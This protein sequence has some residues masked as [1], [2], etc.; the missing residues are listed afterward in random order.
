MRQVPTQNV[1]LAWPRAIGVLIGLVGLVVLGMAG[2]FVAMVEIWW[3]SETFAHGFLIAPIALYLVYRKRDALQRLAP[4]PT[5]WAVPLLFG[6]GAVWSLARLVDVAVIEQAAAVAML[7]LVVWAVLGTAVVRVLLFPLAY[8]FFM[9]PVGEGLIPPLMDFTAR[10]TVGAIRLVG[11]PVF[12][13]GTFFSIPSGNWSVVEGCSG[14]RYLIASVALGALYTYLS[15]KSWVRRLCFMG[16]F[17]VVPIIANGMRAFMIVMIAHFS[18][19]KL[20]LGVDHFI[21][22][23]VFFGLVMFLL[24]TLGLF[25]QEADAE[26]NS[27]AEAKFGAAT[28]N[29][30]PS[31]RLALITP[32]AAGAVVALWPGLMWIQSGPDNE[33]GDWQLALPEQF[34][35]YRRARSSFTTWV[36]AYQNP[37]QERHFW[38]RRGDDWIGVYLARYASQRQNAELINS[39]NQWVPQKH[40]EWQQVARSAHMPATVVALKSVSQGVLRSPS[41]RLLV[42]SWDSFGAWHGASPYV[43]KLM[44]AYQ[45]LRH[46]NDEGIGILVYTPIEGDEGAARERLAGAANVLVQALEPLD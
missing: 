17:I 10:F 19:M 16:L 43:G 46:G 26:T 27:G 42:W 36:P 44:N 41:Q 21:Y 9:V 30:R 31:G 25:F 4:R 37:D 13:E 15:F 40:P 45:Q 18:D 39:Q 7:P 12:V 28:P 8:L 32:W 1:P 24:F 2:S 35:G 14:V 3:R 29:R 20:A 34:S 11:I 23:W 5:F 38:F 6:C 22:G 33:V